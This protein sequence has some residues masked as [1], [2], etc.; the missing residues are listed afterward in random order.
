MWDA[1]S[2]GERK[3]VARPSNVAPPTPSAHGAAIAR[4]AADRSTAALHGAAPRVLVV[5]PDP[6]LR[7][8]Y[9]RALE[10]EG[11]DVV[12]A[13]EGRDALAKA[14]SLAPRLLMTELRLPMIDGYALCEL[15]RH[16]PATRALPILVVTSHVDGGGAVVERAR[17]AGADAVLAKPVELGEIFSE[18]RRLVGT[19][20][21]AGA[22]E[23]PAGAGR[24][25][26]ARARS[27][28]PQRTRVIGSRTHLR[29]NTTTPDAP[30]P[31]LHCPSCDVGLHYK[32]SHIG[33]V[34]S[35]HAEQWDY[36][37]CGGGCGAYQYRQR[38]KKLRRADA[39]AF[40]FLR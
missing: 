26:G 4:R 3:Y 24:D 34:S 1:R 29:F 6:D 40:A 37:V 7:A 2:F 18:A 9:R 21:A 10:L 8:L 15:L 27:A 20:G 23:P 33:G 22:S 39:A 38:T 14:L 19:V 25:T 12:E 28:R 30:P 17:A 35:R 13:S 31:V 5:D 36:Y 32:Y 16:D 11:Y